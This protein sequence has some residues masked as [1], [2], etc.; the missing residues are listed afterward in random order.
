MKEGAVAKFVF[1][2]ALLFR[3][4]HSNFEAKIANYSQNFYFRAQ[5][6]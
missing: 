2:A 4:E 5:Q 1:A 3:S 6:S